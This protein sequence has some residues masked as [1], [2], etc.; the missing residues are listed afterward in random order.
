MEIDQAQPAQQVEIDQERQVKA[1]AY[2][3]IRR[4]LSYIN[5]GIGAI[6]VCLLLFTGMAGWIR[7]RLHSL[8]WQPVH[9]WFPLQVVGFF[10]IVMLAYEIITA[11]LG[12]YG[13]TLSRR[14]GLSVMTLKSWLRDMLV[15]LVLELALGMVALELKIGRA[16][17]RE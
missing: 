7:D 6:G 13:F 5:M 14:Y 8:S 2:A 12:Y 9:G 3:R 11:P 4:R 15:G 16:S 10:L 17:C 1:K